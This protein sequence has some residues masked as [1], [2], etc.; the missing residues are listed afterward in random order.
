MLEAQSYATG[1]WGPDEHFVPPGSAKLGESLESMHASFETPCGSYA[2]FKLT[3]YLLRTTRDSRYGDSMERVMYNTVLGAKTIQSDGLSFYYSDYTFRGRKVYHQDK[4]PCCSG[5]LPQVATDYRISTYFRDGDNVF[6]N[7][8]VPSSVTWNGRS[9]R[10][11]TQYPY[12]GDVRIDVGVPT[13]STF[14]IFLR[15]P[16]WTPGARVT[17]SG[18]RD[19]RPLA[20]GTFAEIRREWRDGDRIELELLRS[21]SL[22]AVDAQHP[23]TVALLQGPL[24]LMAVGDVPE[25]ITRAELLSEQPDGLRLKTFMEI[26]DETYSTYIQVAG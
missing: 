22:E 5:T 25:R 23:D 1:G 6:V 7:L 11:I 3:R 16:D 4:W 8:Y 2:H 18:A 9:L 19:S 26:K 10:Q 20:G 17:V 24:V 14:S 21:N 13:P 15:I 12:S